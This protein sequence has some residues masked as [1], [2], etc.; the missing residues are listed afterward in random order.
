MTLSVSFLP[1]VTIRGVYS[2][3]LALRGVRLAFPDEPNQEKH[4]QVHYQSHAGRD[5]QWGRGGSYVSL[6][7]SE[8]VYMSN[9]IVIC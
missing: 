4:A 8:L 9:I 3:F 2:E 5:I 7:A 6:I 1:T